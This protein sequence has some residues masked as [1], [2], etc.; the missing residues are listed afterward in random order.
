V[1]IIATSNAVLQEKHLPPLFHEEANR[2]G[3]AGKVFYRSM[4]S[5]TKWLKMRFVT[6]DC[7]QKMSFFAENHRGAWKSEAR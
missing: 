5:F 2:W 7:W 3:R 6:P 4:V 1:L